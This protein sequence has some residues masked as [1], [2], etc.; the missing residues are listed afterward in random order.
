MASKF[1]KCDGEWNDIILK[2][3]ATSKQEYIIDREICQ[4]LI[5]V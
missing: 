5:D 3:K 2:D 1:R 4:K